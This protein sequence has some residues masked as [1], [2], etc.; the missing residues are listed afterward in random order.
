M[1]GAEFYFQ[2]KTYL[3]EVTGIPITRITDNQAHYDR[4]YFTSPQFTHDSRYTVFVSDF[5]GTSRIKNPDA[6][7]VGKIGFGELFLLELQTGHAVQLTSGEAIKMGHGAHAMLSPDGNYAYFYS[8]EQLKAVNL[9]TLQTRE[10]MTIPNLYNFHSLS[11]SNDCRYLLFSLVEEVPLITAQ[12]SDPFDGTAPGARERYFK[13]P[14]SL[15]IRYDLEKSHGEVVFGGH[16]RIT[17]ANLKPDDGNKILFCHDGPWD[18]VQRMW[19][20]DAETDVVKPLIEQK[21]NLEQIVHEYFTPT[22]R[23]GAQYSYRYRPD[24][25]YFV[26]ADVFVDF[27]GKNE[28]RYYYPYKRPEH[29]SVGINELLG[30]GDSCM[31]NEEMVQYKKYLS[32][33]HY[34]KD[35]HTARPSLLCCHNSSGRKFA[36]VHPVFT[37]DNQHIIYS[38]DSDGKLNI[39]MVPVLPEKALTSLPG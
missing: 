14:S 8:N 19:T 33:I 6:P 1:K 25:P 27:D 15:I 24:I 39:Y 2:S 7:A 32:L 16:Y 20:V 3:D 12:F 10:L 35:A 30:V 18:L 34:N 5:T 22:G 11:I 29:V 21:R 17:H 4:P 13:Q 26:F 9:S 38:S 37:P 23:I 28:E 36:H 31:L